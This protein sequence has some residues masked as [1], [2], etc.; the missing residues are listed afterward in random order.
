[1][2]F[3][4]PRFS[5][6]PIRR[7]RRK[8]RY[9]R[10]VRRGRSNAV[11]SKSVGSIGDRFFVPLKYT[12]RLNVTSTSGALSI[13]QISGNS[14]FDPDYTS[15]GLQPE[16]WDQFSA[17]FQ[18]YR[19]HASSCKVGLSLTATTA[20]TQTIQFA[21]V[22]VNGTGTESSF[23]DAAAAPYSKHWVGNVSAVG[24]KKL[25]NRMKTTKIFGLP[26]KGL[27]YMYGYDALVSADPANEWIWD[28]YVQPVDTASTVST[29]YLDVEIIYYVEFYLRANLNLS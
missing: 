8:P 25:A 28:V 19:V 21:L 18:R 26:N 1:M 11:I 27:K 12:Q 29:M 7:F 10:K 5:R 22:P 2:A 6:K 23:S 14:A 16:A 13:Y 24:S 9:T 20:A 3:R 15:T 4:K 17:M